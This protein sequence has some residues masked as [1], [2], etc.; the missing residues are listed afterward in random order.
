VRFGFVSFDG[1]LVLGSSGQ[2]RRLEIIE[3]K[4]GETPAKM[5]VSGIYKLAQGQLTV[6]FRFGT[7]SP[8]SEFRTSCGANTMLVVLKQTERSNPPTAP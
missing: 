6:C 8:P 3:T 4:C 2:Q 5:E 7:Q 1:T